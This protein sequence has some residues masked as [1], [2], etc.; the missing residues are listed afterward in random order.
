MNLCFDECLAPM[1]FRRF[2]ELLAKRKT[3]IASIH[4][5]DKV[6]SGAK[7][8]EVLDFLLSQ[9]HRVMVVS[10]DSG[11]NSKRGEPRLH[12]LCPGKVSAVFISPKLCQK[13]GFEKVRSIMVCIPFLQNA[14]DGKIGER[15]RLEATQDGNLYR[16]RP[17]E[18]KEPPTT[19]PPIFSEQ[20]Y[21]Q[22]PS[23]AT[24]SSS[25]HAPSRPSTPP[26]APAQPPPGSSSGPA[27]ESG[28]S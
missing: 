9:S 16:V 10:G 26:I 21:G 22:S 1:W 17:W 27:P 24:S 4:L 15:Y 8:D 12:L 25:P 28:A 14:Y 6:R 3:P 7:D 18:S 23:D 20:L 11:R 5:L 19:A 2:S 13:D